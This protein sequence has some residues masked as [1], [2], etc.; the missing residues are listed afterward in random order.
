MSKS[1]L[2]SVRIENNAYV[3]QFPYDPMAVQMLKQAIPSTGRSWD[4]GRKCWIIAADYKKQAENALGMSFPDI[5]KQ[6]AV[7][8]VKLLTV[9]YL[10]QCKERAPGDVS[11]MGLLHTGAWGAIFPVDVL[12]AWFENPGEVAVPAGVLTLY[13][14]LGAHPSDDAAALKKAYFRMMKQWH[15]DVCHEPDANKMTLRI[16]EAYDILSNPRSRGR[17][18]AGLALEATI[19]KNFDKGSSMRLDSVSQGIYRSP[20]RCGHILV[21]GVDSLGRFVVSRILGWEDI[22]D[23]QGRVMVSSWHMGM[24]KPEIVWA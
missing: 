5:Q 16:R 24:D 22:S 18:D 15:P 4:N 1:P 12:T 17:Y 3:V 13:G 7:K 6:P 9:H 8:V 20:L 10:G 23:A 19:D 14:V 11:A 21:E 2:A